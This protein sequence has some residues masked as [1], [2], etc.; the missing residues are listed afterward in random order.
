MVW[1]G[2]VESQSDMGEG[3]GCGREDTNGDFGDVNCFLRLA[4]ERERERK[5]KKSEGSRSRRV[6]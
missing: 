6:E 2:V 5:R 1:C 3:E 4:E